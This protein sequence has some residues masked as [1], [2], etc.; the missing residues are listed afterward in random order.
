MPTFLVP[1]AGVHG[2][3]WRRAL[4]QWVTPRRS[5]EQVR[6]LIAYDWPGT[7]RELRNHADC[8]ALAIP[9]DAED[10]AARPNLE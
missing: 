10:A 2:L 9:P 7:I 3:S 5:P 8:R 6:H 4:G 1:A